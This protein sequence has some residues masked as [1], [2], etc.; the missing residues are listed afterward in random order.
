[1]MSAVGIY[2]VTAYGVGQRTPEIGLRMALG[3]SQSDI[4]WLVLR[5]GLRRIGIGLVFGLLAAWGLSRVLQSVLV[6]VT[7]ADPLTFISITLLLTLVTLIAC[8]VPS[9]RAMR[10]DPAEALRTE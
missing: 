4:M 2:A 3:A 5:Q 7:A 10:L 1:M 9:R 8:W 6:Q